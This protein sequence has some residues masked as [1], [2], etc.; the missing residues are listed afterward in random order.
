MAPGFSMVGE[1][2]S[3][4]FFSSSLVTFVGD[5]ERFCGTIG[6]PFAGTVAAGF[7]KSRRDGGGGASSPKP[8]LLNCELYVLTVFGRFSVSLRTSIEMDFFLAANA[9]SFWSVGFF[10]AFS[11]VLLLLLLLFF[12]ILPT[13][14]S[15]FG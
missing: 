8:W 5:S 6:M 1:V 4:I 15:D 12:G 3:F 11:V 9:A 2:V 10:M 7:F 13:F 14:S